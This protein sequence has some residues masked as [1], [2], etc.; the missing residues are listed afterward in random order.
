MYIVQM[1]QLHYVSAC[2]QNDA[3]YAAITLSSTNQIAESAHD[4][5]MNMYIQCTD[6][7]YTVPTKT[8]P[9]R[10]SSLDTKPFLN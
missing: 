7:K 9:S 10:V 2:D 6:I 1:T 3:I 4:Y 5:K 8:C